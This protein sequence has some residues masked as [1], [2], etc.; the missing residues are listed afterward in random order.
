V[1]GRSKKA[2][3]EKAA[4]KKEDKRAAPVV[5]SKQAKDAARKAGLLIFF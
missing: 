5:L 3:L 1:C 2:K 4:A